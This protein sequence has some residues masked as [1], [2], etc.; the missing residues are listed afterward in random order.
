MTITIKLNYFE[1]NNNP[2]HIN[3]LEVIKKDLKKIIIFFVKDLFSFYDKSRSLFDFN[4]ISPFSKQPINEVIKTVVDTICSVFKELTNKDIS[5]ET[6][7]Y[8]PPSDGR[9]GF[10]FYPYFQG[11]IV[12]EMNQDTVINDI[13]SEDITGKIEKQDATFKKDSL[14]EY[15][16][17]YYKN[18]ASTS[19]C[20]NQKLI[21]CFKCFLTYYHNKTDDADLLEENFLMLNDKKY[22]ICYQPVIF[23][24]H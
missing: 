10:L 14:Q 15:Y 4:N 11:N 3:D 7:L 24:E 9:K 20:V 21:D 16:T 1:Y 5:A 6:M 13:F 19:I 22:P 23:Q 17:N 12:E 2:N 18:A 8:H